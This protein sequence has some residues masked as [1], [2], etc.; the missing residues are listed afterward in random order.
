M[1]FDSGAYS[2]WQAGQGEID[3]KA[4]ADW[5]HEWKHHPGFDFCIAPDKIDGTEDDNRKLIAI[6]QQEGLLP[7]SV[8][9]WHLHESL[10]YLQYLVVAYRR[11]AFG[12]SGIYSEPGS[13]A[14]WGRMHEAMEVV[15]K[16]GRPQ[17][18]LHGL[19]MLNPTIFSHIPLSSADSTNVAVNIGIDSRWTGS[20]Q[21]LTPGMR[22]LVLK[23]RIEAHASAPRWNRPAY[24]TQMNLELVG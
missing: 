23:D 11:I 6:W 20:Y 17:T 10:E 18:K 1:M 12:S 15:C 4:Y 5:V 14:W 22:A 19:R 8:P 16:D 21:P 7:Y 24:G 2:Y 9:V 3:I 13:D